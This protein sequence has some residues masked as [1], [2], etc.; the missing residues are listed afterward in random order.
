VRYARKT[1]F[2]MSAAAIRKDRRW[3]V[4]KAGAQ[5]RPSRQDDRG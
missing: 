3:L 2:G 5:T 4:K 1:F